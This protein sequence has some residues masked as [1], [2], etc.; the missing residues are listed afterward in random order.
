MTAEDRTD[1]FREKVTLY[2][3]KMWLWLTAIL[4]TYSRKLLR[5]PDQEIISYRNPLLSSRTSI[6]RLNVQANLDG[7]KRHGA[8]I[9]QSEVVDVLKA[10]GKGD[11]IPASPHLHNASGTRP[12]LEI[13]IDDHNSLPRSIF[14]RVHEQLM[15]AVA[16]DTLGADDQYN[17]VF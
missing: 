17:V 10:F 6:T 13:G 2:K 4:H 16:G 9:Q 14:D 7:E 5:P 15:D 12:V 8:R 11:P 3:I 1:S